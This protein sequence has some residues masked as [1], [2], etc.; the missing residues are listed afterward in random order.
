MYATLAPPRLEE[1]L[2]RVAEIAFA[3]CLTACTRT[4]SQPANGTAV[5]GAVTVADKTSV[6]L[7]GSDTMVILGQR[8][9]EDYMKKNPGVTVQV[10]GGGSGTGIA[11]LINGTTDICESSRPMKDEGEG[12]RPGEARR[13]GG[14]DE[15]R[16]GCARGLRQREEP[17][18]GDK[19][20]HV[21]Q[22]LPGRDHELE[23]RREARA[24]PSSSTVGR[25]T[26]A[27]MATSRSTSSR[28][29]TS[30]PQRKRW[31]V[32]RPS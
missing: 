14:R 32:R 3:V 15:G 8:W 13:A 11:A 21:A 6:T 16:P 5:D 17:R 7:K 22:D 9:A 28:T 10:T 29:R 1:P 30:R 4:E 18:H 2:S 27:R 19:H 20:P 25:T 23:G 31:P 26:R 24:T 12:G